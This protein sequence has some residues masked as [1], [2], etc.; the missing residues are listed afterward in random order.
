MRPT[1][2]LATATG[3]AAA[4]LAAWRNGGGATLRAGGAE[5]PR[6]ADVV[7]YRHRTPPA[8][9]QHGLCGSLADELDEGVGTRVAGGVPREASATYCADLSATAS[10]QRN[11]GGGLVLELHEGV[12]PRSAGGVPSEARPPYSAD[13]AKYVK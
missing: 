4:E 7:I 3:A 9:R 8:S 10:G 2:A 1:T 12:A 13:L 6:V 5:V 11:L